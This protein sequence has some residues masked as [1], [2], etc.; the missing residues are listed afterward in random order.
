MRI[1]PRYS[2][3]L[4][5]PFL[6]SV[7]LFAPTIH[8]LSTGIDADLGITGVGYEYDN[9]TVAQEEYPRGQYNKKF[10]AIAGEVVLI[11]KYR[12]KYLLKLRLREFAEK[13]V[14]VSSFWVETTKY[15]PAVGDKYRILGVFN[16]IR[17]TIELWSILNADY[18]LSGFCAVNESTSDTYFAIQQC[19]FW[20]RGILPKDAEIN[21]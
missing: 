5:F 6:L 14:W 10:S 12:G 4:L 13:T 18:L 3:G 20:A 11:K 16:D 2:F 8:G 15:I 7:S 19:D 17:A 9:K 1:F 21:Y